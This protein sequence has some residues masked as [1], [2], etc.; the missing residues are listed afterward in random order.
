VLSVRGGRFFTLLKN[1]AANIAGGL[2]NALLAVALPSILVRHLAA[3]SFDAW[4]V[5]L[6]LAAVVN[7]FQFG[8][9]VAVGR[10]VAFHTARAEP[11]RRAEIANTALAALWLLAGV[12]IVA[13]LIAAWLL[14]R[15]IPGMPD[16]VVRDARLALIALG[17]GLALGLP[18]TAAAGIYTGLQ[19]NEIPALFVVVSRIAIAVAVVL[20]ALAGAG[21]VAIATAYGAIIAGTAI[22]QL[23][24]A[25]THLPEFEFRRERVTR[26]AGR[27]LVSY[28]TSMTIWSMAM[29]AI[30]GLDAVIA[31]YFDF[32]WA[33]YYAVAASASALLVGLQAAV[34]QPFVAIA[35][36]LASR[37]ERRRLG[38]L[39]VETTYLNTLAFMLAG[40]LLIVA[41]TP[42]LALWLGADFGAKALPVVQVVLAGMLL[43]QTLA[44]Y[45][46]FLLGT[47][48]Q[49]LLIL[50]P[51][52]EA[53]AKLAASVALA[54]W[55]GPLGVAL[56]TVVGAIVCLATN[57]TL[58]YPRVRGIEMPRSQ[59]TGRGLLRP[60]LTVAPLLVAGALASMRDG[61]AS[62]PIAA[63][64][65]VV[66]LAAV[67]ALGYPSLRRLRELV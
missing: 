1:S 52:Y 34:L 21:I 8:L 48:E 64:I 7:V 56:G 4:A 30:G 23:R 49:R 39:L 63:A 24:F 35:A 36:S 40:V 31:G 27:E 50:P 41:G 28:C 61:G 3:P 43:R 6:Q 26:A 33:G 20:L 54:A 9:Q 45:A 22:V 57:L 66:A 42:L 37:G 53:A 19:R 12:A 29:L 13:V 51:L 25:A 46:T 47:G 60:V 59:F 10:Y 44:P 11:A 18:A 67:I 5:V 32:R 17:S 14:P 15:W 55:I 2:A 58:T 38:A 62:P 16:A 65:V